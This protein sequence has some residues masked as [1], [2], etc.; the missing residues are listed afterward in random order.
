[1]DAGLNVATV[2]VRRG[3][4]D[5]IE[6]RCDDVIASPA[7]SFAKRG[8]SCAQLQCGEHAVR[9]MRGGL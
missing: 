5:V 8:R 7:V 6:E 9:G 2:R 1:M 4:P 3:G